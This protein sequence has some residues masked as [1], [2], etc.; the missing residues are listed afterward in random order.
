MK[1]L[2]VS[3]NTDAERRAVLRALRSATQIPH[4][5]GYSDETRQMVMTDAA[6]ILDFHTEVL[7][8]LVSTYLLN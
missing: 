1:A 6:E 7:P 5:G 3:A 2:F 4:Q 8:E